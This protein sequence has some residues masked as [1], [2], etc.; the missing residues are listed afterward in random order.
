VLNLVEL[1]LPGSFGKAAL[2]QLDW[3]P[4]AEPSTFC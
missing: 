3:E 2:W 1:D 4:E